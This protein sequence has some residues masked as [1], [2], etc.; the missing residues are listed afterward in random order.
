MRPKAKHLWS[1][2]SPDAS[3]TNISAAC[4]IL[5]LS[6]L[7]FSKHVSLISLV[8]LTLRCGTL[9]EVAVYGLAS[10]LI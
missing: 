5:K 2:P 3:R 9:L 7:A 10:F 8:R 4:F 1:V 6:F